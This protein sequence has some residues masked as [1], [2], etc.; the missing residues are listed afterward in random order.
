MKTKRGFQLYTGMW[1]FAVLLL[2]VMLLWN[3]GDARIINYAGLVRGA[4]QRLVK[5]EMNGKPD[6][7]LIA[8]LDGIIYD[9]QT[10]KGDYGLTK[11]SNKQFQKQLSELNGIW[12]NMKDEINSVRSGSTSDVRLYDLSQQHFEL[13]DRLV[14]QA[15]QDSNHKLIGFILVYFFILFLSIVVF[16]IVNKRNQ[17][18]LET[19]I[20]TDKLTGLLNRRA[21]N[22][23]PQAC[24]ASRQKANLLLLHLI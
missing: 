11:N 15:E 19:A 9:L 12:E 5:E 6:D 16:L 22:L 21:L 18:K 1:M 8:R 20:S 23:L 10:G 4:T 17:R 3:A 24:C 7:E 14:M 2:A 13:A